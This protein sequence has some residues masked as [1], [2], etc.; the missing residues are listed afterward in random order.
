[1][2]IHKFLEI[3]RNELVRQYKENELYIDENLLKTQPTSVIIDGNIDVYRLAYML[4]YYFEQYE[5]S[6]GE[7]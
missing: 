6:K 4:E 5:M 1:M 3:I 7:T 2:D